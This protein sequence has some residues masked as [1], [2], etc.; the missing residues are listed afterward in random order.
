MT[1]RADEL[2]FEQQLQAAYDKGRREEREVIRREVQSK[3]YDWSHDRNTSGV[4][5]VLNWLDERTR[6]GL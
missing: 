2:T 5:N 6:S 1:Y 4:Q 3:G